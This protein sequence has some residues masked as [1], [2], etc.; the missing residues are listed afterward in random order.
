[1]Q[2]TKNLLEDGLKQPR[3]NE[4]GRESSSFPQR[5]EV[6]EC[7]ISTRGVNQTLSHS[8]KV[9][10]HVHH[11][12]KMVLGSDLGLS[13]VARMSLCSLIG[14]F[15]YKTTKTYNVGAWMEGNWRPLLG[16]VL[17]L[18]VSS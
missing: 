6:L 5:A 10:K 15:G 1:M 14:K 2:S 9:W 13:N 16:Y 17:V 3:V 18:F 7:C 8:Q 12:S 11:R 4:V